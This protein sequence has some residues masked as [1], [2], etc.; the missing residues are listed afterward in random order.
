[1]KKGMINAALRMVSLG[2]RA[3]AILVTGTD[4]IR[5]GYGNGDCV[6][7]DFDHSVFALSDSTERYS[8]GSREFLQRLYAA[9]ASKGVP[10]DIAA[11][12]ALVN[13]V[14][15]VQDYRHKATF[16]CAAL[17]EG[18]DGIV[19]TALNGGDSSIAV[20]NVQSK[21]IKYMSSPDMNFAGRSTKISHVA[22][23][24]ISRDCLVA[25]FSDGI[26]DIARLTEQSVIE[27]IADASR[28]GVE[29]V[30]ARMREVLEKILGNSS[31]EYDDAALVVFDPFSCAKKGDGVI[32]MGGSTPQ[33]ETRYQ[34]HV[35]PSAKWDRWMEVDEIMG[36]D[37]L[38]R[39][40][41][42][43]IIH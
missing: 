28:R 12:R 3:G 7:M 27:L 39:E 43:R 34:T 24:Q 14:Y 23:V 17:R 29:T 1:M 25:I 9:L 37:E 21:A 33:E 32:I 40:C 31:V 4:K 8:R 18:A 16:S 42:I 36:N 41:A 22:E 35:R 13:E 26:A 30:P 19:L 5:S 6:M 15:A 20:V 38:A 10:H 2:E 11:W